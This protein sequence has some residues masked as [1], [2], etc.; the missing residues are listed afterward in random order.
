MSIPFIQLP[1]ARVRFVGP[2]YLVR[3]FSDLPN[4]Q[5]FYDTSVNGKK[6][7]KMIPVQLDRFY[8][9]SDTKDPRKMT[10][11]SRELV[12][13]VA[14]VSER[15]PFRAAFGE[16]HIDK[17]HLSNALL[18]TPRPSSRISCGM[19]DKVE[20]GREM[21]N[22]LHLSMDREVYFQTLSAYDYEEA[23]NNRRYGDRKAG[24]NAIT[25][26][27]KIFGEAF[28][29]AISH[30]FLDLR[31]YFP[32]QAIVDEIQRTVDHNFP[33]LHSSGLFSLEALHF[34]TLV[35]PSIELAPDTVT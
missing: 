30:P 19:I 8:R 5:L 15:R 11:Y 33:W 14:A 9:R 35:T 13:N 25:G 10:A 4:L 27:V 12:K 29:C 2:D 26:E 17:N 21:K 6:S 31:D 34:E 22:F 24:H 16:G 1:F 28:G 18:N 20:G 32:A 3:V 7:W 23:R